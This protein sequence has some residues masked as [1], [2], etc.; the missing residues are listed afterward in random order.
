[1]GSKRVVISVCL[2]SL[3]LMCVQ[4]RPIDPLEEYDSENEVQQVYAAPTPRS[5]SDIAVQHITPKMKASV[6]Q[7]PTETTTEYI[8]QGIVEAYTVEVDKLHSIRHAA[9]T[10]YYPVAP[11]ENAYE[12][13]MQVYKDSFVTPMNRNSP[14]NVPSNVPPPTD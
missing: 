7:S 11:Q 4:G 14:S 8:Y 1:M 12:K 9:G 10:L 6:G 2:I 5:S 3:F 13:L